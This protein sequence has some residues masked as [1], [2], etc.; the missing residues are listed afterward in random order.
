VVPDAIPN[1]DG[2]VVLRVNAANAGPSAHIHY[3][4]VRGAMARPSARWAAAL[5]NRLWA[6]EN[7]GSAF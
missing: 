2:E 5:S 4:M 3:A 1:D 7:L 6:G